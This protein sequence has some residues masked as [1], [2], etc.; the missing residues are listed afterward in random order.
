MQCAAPAQTATPRLQTSAARALV[1]QGVTPAT[2]RGTGAGTG[3]RGEREEGQEAERAR[4]RATRA[5]PWAWLP[6]EEQMTPGARSSS[7]IW[8]ILLCAPRTLKE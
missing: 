6:A 4:V 7:V 1:Q 8:A 3:R 2:G 5:T